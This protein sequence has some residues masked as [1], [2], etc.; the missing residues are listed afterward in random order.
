MN[1]L[2]IYRITTLVVVFMVFS[3]V[4]M[5]AKAHNPVVLNDRLESGFRVPPDSIQTSVYWYWISDNISEQGVVKDLQAMK[6]AGIN[7]AFI[8]NIGLADIPYGKVKML[9]EE[10]WK[11]LHTALR[12]ATEL[13][14]DIGIFNSPGWSQSGGPWV[15]AENA[16]RYIHS[17]EIRVKGPGKFTQQLERP[18]ALFQDVKVVAYPAP[19]GYNRVV[20][21]GISSVESFPVLTDLEKL[22]D[23]NIETELSLPVSATITF[24]FKLQQAFTARSL[25]ITTAKVPTT[26]TVVFQAKKGSST[27]FETIAEHAVDRSN[28]NLHVGFVPYAPVTISFPA[29]TAT[30]FRLLVKNASPGAGFS[31]IEI[32]A[33]PRVERYSEKSLAKM[34][35]TPLPYWH[36][37]Q[38]TVQPEPDDIKTVLDSRKMVDLS[39]NLSP[40]GMLN[41]DVPEGDWIIFRSGMT[42]TGVVNSPASP[43]ATGYEV[44]KMNRQHVEKHFYGHMGEIL[45]RIPAADRRSFKVVVADS[46]ET[47]SQNFTDDFAEDFKAK[48]GYDLFPYLPVFQGKVVNSQAESDRFLWD[49]RRLV[50]DKV[51]YEYVGA[52]KEVANKNGL[53][54]WLENYGHWGFPGEFLQYGGQSDEIAG[55]FWSEGDLGNIENRAASSAGHIYGINKISAESFTCGGAA[56]SRYPA[57]I[58]QRGDRFFAEGINNTLLHVYISQPYENKTP[59]VN[60]PFGNEFNRKNTWFAHLDVFVDYLKRTNFMLQQGLNVAD[61]AYFIGEDAPKMTGIINPTLPVGYQFDYMNAEV[62][63][64]YMTVKNGLITL[65]HG[66]QYRMLVLPQLETMRP[67]LLRKIYSLVLQ[68]AVVLGPAPK[69][70]PSLQNQPRADQ[71]LADLVRQLWGE[72]DGEKVTKRKVGMGM[73]M[74]GIDLKD[75]LQLLQCI[76]DCQLPSDNTIHYAH[77]VTPEADIYFLTN[78]TNETRIVSPEFRVANRIPEIWEATTGNIRP[79]RAYTFHAT[80]TAV[81]LKL[82]PNESVFIV[83]RKPETRNGKTSLVDNYPEPVNTIEVSKPWSVQFEQESRGPLHAV[84]FQSLTDWSTS[85][86]DSIKYY[87]GIATYSNQ[88]TLKKRNKQQ[89]VSISLG[90]VTAMAKVYINEQYAGGLWTAPFE[91]DIT[92]YIKKG[93]NTLR[94]EVVNTWVNRLIGDLRLP[95][96]QRK[97]WLPVNPYTADSPLQPSGL[98]GPVTIVIR[99]N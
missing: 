83:F 20:N 14:I 79:L 65:P 96:E 71:E 88:F 93:T 8:G 42:P 52:L 40:E 48:Y 21:T 50:A 17:S 26:A 29:Y 91:A 18:A 99:E 97:T 92:S 23:G 53:T 7:R 76:P 24:D 77:R 62:I 80:A 39:A 43:E 56:F 61:V 31:E 57:T 4:D 30:H 45:R 63:E 95:I 1:Q 81:P 67:E 54:L 11:I 49:V 64:K 19:A 33:S 87:S 32:S 15:K 73:I 41:W 69:R 38:W 72:V 46:Y 36:E 66:T 94:I 51:S 68:G 35:Q 47:G 10:W 82:A 90:S 84:K 44:D 58:K 86:N 59:G 98:L 9:S 27:E 60:A 89:R 78:Q 75:A 12:T 6:K 34:H 13:N 5:V 37:Y 3:T 70:S 25:S 85:A 2:R 22:I 55:E 16:M 28:P 74:N